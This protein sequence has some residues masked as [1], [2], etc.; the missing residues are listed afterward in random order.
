M[1]EIQQV[2]EAIQKQ[3]STFEKEMQ[4]LML[5]ETELRSQIAAQVRW[6]KFADSQATDAVLRDLFEKN[7]EMFDGSMVRARHILL[8][9]ASGD[10]KAN[11]QAKQKLD[12]FKRQVDAEVFAGLA[13][14]P[15]NTD[16]Q[17]R[18]QA[19]IKL[20]DTSFGALARKESACPSKAED[21][22]LGWF[23]RTGSMVEPFAKVA[24]ALRP[25]QMSDVVTTQ[26]GYH[27]ILVTDRRPGKE[28]KFEDAKD[29]V[30]EMFEGRLREDLLARLRPDAKVA[31]NPPAKN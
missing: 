19:R 3:G 7:R 30:R 17:A 13:K 5:T 8:T 12:D 10:A 11:E 28:T 23:A 9:P 2:R 31:V 15:E 6:D 16:P 24:F 18:E 14:L 29:D 25:Y 20:M 21:G 4:E 26:F 1:P 22:D 27:L